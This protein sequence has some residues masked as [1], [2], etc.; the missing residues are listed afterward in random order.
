[1][2]APGALSMNSVPD[3]ASRPAKRPAKNGPE[4]APPLD[5][6]THDELV[7]RVFDVI[8]TLLQGTNLAV[9]DDPISPHIHTPPERLTQ[10]LLEAKSLLERAF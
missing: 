9:I 2:V 7:R 10:N 4:R 8:E 3:M 6:T 5:T 1:M